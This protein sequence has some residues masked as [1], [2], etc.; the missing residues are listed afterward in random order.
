MKAKKQLFDYCFL[1][2]FPTYRI[3]SKLVYI[4]IRL[5]L[6]FTKNLRKIHRPEAEIMALKGGKYEKARTTRYY[7]THARSCS[8]A[9]K[10]VP[11]RA[12][13][14]LSPGRILSETGIFFFLIVLRDT[15]KVPK[16]IWEGPT[17]RIPLNSNRIFLLFFLDSF[18]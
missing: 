11:T 9:L 2:F 1:N 15:Q 7:F 18:R 3:F 14:R 10:R 13:D 16:P 8:R 6:V 5:I 4:P 12:N 17:V